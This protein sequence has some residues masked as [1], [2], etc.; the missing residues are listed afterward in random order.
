MKPAVE[1]QLK[2]QIPTP[3]MGN[4]EVRLLAVA[5]NMVYA[6]ID[7]GSTYFSTLLPATASRDWMK[8]MR[9]KYAIVR[10]HAVK[11]QTDV[12]IQDRVG[13]VDGIRLYVNSKNG[14]LP[15]VIVEQ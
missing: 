1:K 12:I 10:F 14:K 6:V 7:N 5:D 3:L 2:V 15:A 4:Y 9:D 11:T 8:T 13:Y